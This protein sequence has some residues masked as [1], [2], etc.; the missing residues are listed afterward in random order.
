MRAISRTPSYFAACLVV[1]WLTSTS[2]GHLHA[3][4]APADDLVSGLKQFNDLLDAYAE[5]HR[6]AAA[7]IPALERNATPEKISTA[8][9][10]LAGRIIAARAHVKRGSIFTP[11]VRRLLRSIIGGEIEAPGGA[12]AVAA[13]MESAPRKLKLKVNAPYPEGVPLSTVP[14]AL[15]LT[16]PKLPDVLEYRFIGR[17]LILRDNRANIVVDYIEEA[18][19]GAGS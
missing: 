8:E 2:A 9:H 14:P 6:K 12:L 5:L 13:I 17:D 1:A 3:S 16:L 19:P 11:D 18:I 10:L 15:L 4:S 7:S